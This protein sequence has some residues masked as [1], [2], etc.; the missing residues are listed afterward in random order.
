MAGKH[1]AGFEF[2]RRVARA[3]GEPPEKVLRIAGLLPARELDEEQLELLLHCFD[4]MDEASREKFL[5]IARVFA[6]RGV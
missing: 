5:L 3:F 2:C 4:Q 6:G 1:Q